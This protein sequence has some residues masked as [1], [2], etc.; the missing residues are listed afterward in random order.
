LRKVYGLSPGEIAA[1]LG[2]SENTVSAQ[3]SIGLKRCAQFML[4]RRD[5]VRSST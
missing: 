4:R 2:V 5:N 1:K 3:L